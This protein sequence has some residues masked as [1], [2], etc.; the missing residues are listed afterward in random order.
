MVVILS[1]SWEKLEGSVWERNEPRVL[2]AMESILSLLWFP[3]KDYNFLWQ[4]IFPHSIDKKSLDSKCVYACTCS[5]MCV[6]IWVW[7]CVCECV[8]ACVCVFMSVCVHVCICMWVRV[9]WLCAHCW[10]LLFLMDICHVGFRIAAIL[11]DPRRKGHLAVVLGD[12]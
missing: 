5:C 12:S 3:V 9:C 8:Y 4:R 7:M 6:C 10:P 11:S 1:Y 2:E